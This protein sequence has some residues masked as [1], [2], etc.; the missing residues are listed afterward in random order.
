M[1][2]LG[3]IL[4]LRWGEAAGQRV[5]DID[6]EVG[7]LR[8]SHQRTRGEHGQMLEGAP[9]SKA[10]NRVMS[11]PAGLVTM[12]RA[13]LELRGLTD[14]DAEAYLFAGSRGA[15][16]CR[17]SL[18]TLEGRRTDAVRDRRGAFA[19]RGRVQAGQYR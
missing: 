17:S 12:V 14:A 11:M 13:H 5:G 16:L 2:Y 18:A 9:N 19:T 10:G 7:A 8:V 4:G 15:A 6:L 3:A 1:V